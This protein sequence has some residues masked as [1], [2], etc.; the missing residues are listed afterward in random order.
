M[1]AKMIVLGK[2]VSDFF[3]NRNIN[4]ITIIIDYKNNSIILWGDEKERIN[5]RY[6]YK[7]NYK[8]G[9]KIYYAGIIYSQ[10]KTQLYTKITMRIGDY[11]TVLRKDYAAKQ[12]NSRAVIIENVKLLDDVIIRGERYI[13]MKEQFIIMGDNTLSM[14]ITP[15]DLVRKE[16]KIQTNQATPIQTQTQTSRLPNTQSQITQKSRQLP[17][18]IQEKQV[19]ITPNIIDDMPTSEEIAKAEAEYKKMILGD[20]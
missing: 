17:V 18:K 16:R 10:P 5:P 2:R 20:D 9:Y 6:N 7:I 13:N 12:L 14:N 1:Y 4:T 19:E 8:T 15:E 3:K 11:L